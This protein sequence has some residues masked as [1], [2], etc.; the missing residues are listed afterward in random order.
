[1]NTKSIDPDVLTAAITPYAV[2]DYTKSPPR[3]QVLSVR[4]ANWFKRRIVCAA[5]KAFRT[6]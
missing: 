1:M 2:S 5:A 4:R 3:T 6:N